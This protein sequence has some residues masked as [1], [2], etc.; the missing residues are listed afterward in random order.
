[1]SRPLEDL[2]YYA[3]AP[4]RL[5]GRSRVLRIVVAAVVV[6][7][8]CF[9]ATLWALDR[10]FP[11]DNGAREA[12]AKLPK[13][14]PLPPITRTSYVLA[15]VAVSLVAIRQSL[16]NGTPREFSGKNDNPASKILSK[17]D[18]GLTV[19]RGSMSIT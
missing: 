2:I 6:I 1:M 11:P 18:I 12:L 3:T 7:G 16:D 5:F 10:F 19:S 8:A 13:P 15:P 14:P 9:T 4:L 17:A